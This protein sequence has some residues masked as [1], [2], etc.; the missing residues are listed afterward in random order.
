MDQKKLQVWLPLFLSLTMVAGM[1]IGYKMRDKMPRK[2]F[3]YAERSKPIQEILDLINSKYVDDISADSLADTAISA[4][5]S[6]L[7]PHSQYIPA[8]SVERAN[9]DI[10][11]SFYGVG[12][13]FNLIEDTLNVIHVFKDG[14][15][16][17]AGLQVGD[18]FLQ[19][20]DSI[21]AGRKKDAD[22]LRKIL[23]GNRGTK[24]PLVILRGK[25]K[26]NKI[27][28]RDFVHV[29]SVDAAYMINETTGFIRLNK[30]SQ[31]TYREF[32]Q[33]LEKLKRAGLKKLILDLRDN[34]GG[35]LDDAV[36]IADEFLEGD[37]LITYT[38]GKHLPKKEFRCRREGQFEKGPLIILADEG[39]ASASEVLIGALQDW[40][41]AIVVGK[42]TF[43]KG[44]VQEQFDLSDGSALRLTVSRY[45]TPLGRSIQRSYKAGKKEYYDEVLRRYV[46]PDSSQLDSVTYRS[47]KRFTTRNGKAVYEGGGITPDYFIATDTARFG[48]HL[49]KIY[50]K[51]LVNLFGYRYVVDH[52]ELKKIPSSQEFS[53]NFNMEEE[54]WNYFERMARKDSID[55][56]SLTIPEKTFLSRG[57]KLAIARQLW[58][59]EGF[60]LVFNREDEAVLKAMQLLSG[61]K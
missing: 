50:T 33:S 10:A 34:G 1:F 48:T 47:G 37:R 12:I 58:R 9:E 52:E 55:I 59:H 11:G 60:F 21:I 25:T 41:R 2:S 24:L 32:M 30:F 31:Q 19:A 14:P 43:G 29:T 46:I 35:V 15:A 8:K 51:G 16:F 57:L 56:Q 5:L 17:K 4:L 49:S 20:A 6:K 27:V 28:S 42:R 61:E 39:S 54:G 22:D 38:M 23:K 26:L 36:E 13:E 18:K 53:K 45:Y 3:F 44:L 7:D 40:D